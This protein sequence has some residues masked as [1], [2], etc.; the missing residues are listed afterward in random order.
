MTARRLLAAFA[1]ILATLCAGTAWLLT[2]EGGLRAAVQLA[3]MALGD[4]L[5]VASP[6][7]R[8]LGPL[9]IGEVRWTDPELQLSASRVELDWSPAEL[10][11]RRLHI[12]A[13]R[14][15]A[16]Q[17][18]PAP[19][20]APAAL[21]SDLTLPLAINAKRVEIAELRWDDSLGVT[22]ISA[23]LS[24]DGRRHRLTDVSARIADT[25]LSGRLEL[26]GATPFP[27][28]AQARAH[29]LVAEHS[30]AVT[31]DAQGSLERL[32]V[33]VSAQEGIAGEAN[34][35]IAPFAATPLVAARVA[36]RDID[37]AAWQTDA[38]HARL[39]VDAELSRTND[40]LTGDIALANSIPGPIDK[41]QLPLETARFRLVPENND[42]RIDAIALTLPGGGSLHGSGRFA[43]E[44][45]TLD[46][47]A[48]R[49]DAARMASTLVATRLDGPLKLSLGAERQRGELSLRDTR[50]SLRAQVEHAGG[51]L[52]IDRIN[53]AS[54]DARL[55]A[56]GTLGL[57]RERP[58]SVR[59]ELRQFD[60]SRFI[61]APQAQE[62]LKSSSPRRRPGSSLLG[63]LDS[64]LRRNDESSINQRTP[65]ETTRINARF[66]AEGR[67]A[68]APVIDG[69]FELEESRFAGQPLAGSGRLTLAWPNVSLLDVAITAGEN[70]L[71]AKGSFGRPQDRLT[72]R[73]DAPRLAP[74]GIDGSLSGK[75]DLGGTPEQPTLALD[76]AAP[77]LGHP[78]LGRIDN[79]SV[80]ARL[81]EAP[82]AP[83][84]LNLTA[85]RFD[86]PTLPA[87]A[88]GLRARLDGSRQ[89]HRLEFN[90]RLGDR[91]L[92]LAATGGLAA[93]LH[94]RGTLRELR[95][96]IT[97]GP[98]LALSEPTPLDAGASGWSVGPARLTGNAPDW[99][100]ELRASTDI[101]RLRADLTGS[102]TYIGRFGGSLDA[103]MD[104]P[105]ALAPSAPWLGELRLE[106]DDLAWLGDL[107][108]DGW[109]T[110]G[111]FTGTLALAGTPA[112][113][114][115]SGRFQGDRLLVRQSEQGLH[116]RDG[117]LAATLDANRLR[118]E[119]L[120]FASELSAPPRPLRVALGDDVRRFETPGRLAISG[121]LQIDRSESS[122]FAG[123]AA[124]DIRLDRVGAWQL[125]D[126]WITV[127]GNGRMTWQGGSL[128][129]HG[130]LGVDAGYWQ[131]APAGM[132]RLSDDVMVI[133][134]GAAAPRAPR[135][136]L[137]L[138]VTA[139]LGRRFLFN[140][141]GLTARLAGDVRL[142]ARGRDLPRASG[143]I[144]TREGRFDAYGQ[145]LAIERG[146]L[147]FQ[148]LLDNPALD[149]LAVRKGLAVEPGVQ[150]AGTARRPVV[151]LVSDPELPDADKLAWLVL[152]HG[153]E[154]MSAADATVLIGAAGG[155]L[156]NS[157]G[158]VV[159][160]LKTAFGIDEFGVRQGDIGG[161]SAYRPTSRIAASSVDTSTSTG[162][163]ILSIG[164]RLSSNAVL[165][166]EQS[167]G[168]AEN[169][170]K[171]TVNLSRR[172]ALIGRAGSD[173]ALDLFYTV[174]FGHPPAPA[175]QK[176][177]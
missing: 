122:E 116:L 61:D 21:P 12:A 174:T 151:R 23:G 147:S 156:G 20:E 91:T 87:P 141:A 127:S 34:A 14:I 53:L 158:S 43:Q 175:R 26:D 137:D 31:L 24:S 11:S 17:I 135:P 118:I 144:Q 168:T 176:T 51:M 149:V 167:L 114:E 64:G 8:L 164:K 152:G 105:W 70:H 18:K 139:D 153:P 7:G 177:D 95:V 85:S 60:P 65:K 76:L 56:A 82:E 162:S 129:I 138:D 90:A 142:T 159:Q 75:I 81:S 58:F 52:T 154:T 89:D 115:A 25:A 37:P 88:T 68:P 171:L 3:G 1:L 63:S 163:Q 125:P 32:T 73:I 157:S 126:Q 132:P 103:G 104:G 112:H 2:T 71:T 111:R 169:V 77:R 160:Q 123:R 84:A 36:L 136:D 78:A 124:L 9:R 128:G 41:N 94:W 131:L 130:Q 86:S 155:L 33:S 55:H 102:G 166:Y 74:F 148:G 42:L 59:G 10:L 13:L 38:P 15:D 107:L 100:A 170:V 165:S 93:D 83:L 92:Q 121:D 45:L 66:D 133:R 30:L 35:V 110:G 6:E 4:R 161:D 28:A 40:A 48:R 19:S 39:A 72:L 113:P 119:K 57:Q 49:L 98:R 46:L 69:H 27:V 79:L 109:R 54:G 50:F 120:S 62:T 140:G 108:G 16:L 145:Q 96:D 106:T 172:L 47:D 5:H 99:Q 150:V 67:L 173:N 146:I 117:E 97:D 22:D 143:V 134:P 80:Q 101:R 29:G 44:T